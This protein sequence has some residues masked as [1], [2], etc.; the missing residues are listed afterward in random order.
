MLELYL[1]PKAK[2]DLAKIWYDTRVE[3]GE[4]QADRYI[5]NIDAAFRRLLEHPKLGRACDEVR[6]G[7]RRHITGKHVIFYRIMPEKIRI[8][9]QKMDA[10]SHVR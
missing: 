10:S 7:Y 9:H 3:W 6:E 2:R 4:E 8:L 5:S 1:R